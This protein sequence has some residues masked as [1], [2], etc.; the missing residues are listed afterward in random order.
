MRA[1][2]ALYRDAS[3]AESIR[4]HYE[5]SFEIA[6]RYLPDTGARGGFF[7]WLPVRDDIAFVRRAYETQALRIM[8]GRFMAVNT[9][10]GNPGDGYIRVALVHDHDTIEAA[11]MRLAQL[12]EDER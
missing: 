11:M 3:H 2:G 12:Y 7:L 4:R 1:S 9:D 6:E 10:N 5:I 8:P